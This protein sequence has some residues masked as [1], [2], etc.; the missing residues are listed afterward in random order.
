MTHTITE[1][2]LKAFDLPR[3]TKIIDH[4]PLSPE[5]ASWISMWDDS[6]PNTAGAWVLCSGEVITW[7]PQRKPLALAYPADRWCRFA[8]T[9]FRADGGIEEWGSKEAPISEVRPSDRL[10][11]CQGCGEN[12]DEEEIFSVGDERLCEG[13]AEALESEDDR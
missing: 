13:C 3:G 9:F 1:E 8:V 7:T 2:A 10:V 4:R 6:L 11:N 12:F 5:E